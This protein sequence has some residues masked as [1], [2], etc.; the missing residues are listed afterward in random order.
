M[1]VQLIIQN[2]DPPK[3]LNKS[4][5]NSN[6]GFG[7]CCLYHKMNTVLLNSIQIKHALFRDPIFYFFQL[8]NH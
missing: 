5:V 2:S 6:N 3:T 8:M 7:I 1:L 4:I